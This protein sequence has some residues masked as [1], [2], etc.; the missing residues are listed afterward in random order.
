MAVDLTLLNLILGLIC[1]CNS[2]FD[3]ESSCET[4]G[5]SWQTEQFSDII[6]GFWDEGEVFVD[7]NGVYNPPEDYVDENANGVYDLGEEC[8]DLN[9][10]NQWDDGEP[11]VDDNENGQYDFELV[12]QDENSNSWSGLLSKLIKVF[13]IG[14]L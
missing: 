6:N 3:T 4:A 1:K 2:N 11:F 13:I 10:N 5:D 9:H 14:S 12:Y 8:T 7:G